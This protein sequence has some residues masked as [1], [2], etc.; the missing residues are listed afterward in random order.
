[1]T[2][3]I[4][5]ILS[6]SRRHRGVVLV[7]MLV[8]VAA[9]VVAMRGLRFDTNV[10]S[11]LP[12]TGTIVPAFSTFVE[13]FGSVDDLY[14]VLTAPQGHGIREYDD[15]VETWAAKLRATPG[16][17]RVDTGLADGSRDLTWFA[18][19]RL[20]LLSGDNLTKGLNRFNGA[21]LEEALRQ[22]RSLLTLPSA[23]VVQMVRYDPLGLFDLLRDELGALQAGVNL[24]AT[25]GGYISAD[26]QSRLLIAKPTRAPFD[27]EFSKQLLASLEALRR[28]RGRA[29]TS[30]RDPASADDERPPLSAEF[31]GGHRIAVETES[32]IRREAIMN[33]IGS[34]ALI[35]PLLYLVFRSPWLVV[36]GSI[37]S[38]V[39]LV[40]VLGVLGAVG[41]TLSAAATASS[42]MLFGLG[43]DGVVLL[44]VAYTHAIRA[45][46]DPN[47]AIDGL[48][49]PSASMLLGMCTTA[50]TF[51]GLLLVDF[52][53]LEQLGALI[54]HSMLVCGPL[55]LILV[56]ALL[57]RRR[58]SRPPRA[59]AMPR[60]A[61]WVDRHTRLILVSALALTI[62]MA[63]AATRLQINPTLDRLRA[64]TPGAIQLQQLGR[65]FGLP[66]E[67]YVVV[68]SGDDLDQL[69]AANERL[70]S[71]LS[72]ALPAVAVHAP[73]SLLPSPDVQQQRQSLIRQR[74]GT[75][76]SIATTLAKAETAEGFKADSF[77]PFLD[78]VP[79]LIDPSLRLTYEDYKAHGLDDLIGRFVSRH[80][81]HW[82]LA[83]YVFPQRPEDVAALERVVVTVDPS[84]ILTGLARVNRELADRFLPELLKGLSIGTIVVIV[85]VVIA[86]RDVRLSLL[87][88]VPTIIGLVWAAG[89]LAIAGAA[90]DLFALFAVVTFVGIGVDYGVHMVHRYQE[91][92][93]APQAVSELAPV[94]LTAALIT[95]LGYGTLVTSSYPPLRSIGLVSAVSVATLAL[96]SVFVLPAILS[97]LAATSDSDA[98]SSARPDAGSGPDDASA[99]APRKWTLHGLNNGVIFTLTYHG[100]RT[101][102]RSV[103]YALG[104]SLT[105]I[106]WRTL[107]RTREAIAHNLAPLF[108]TEDRATLERRALTTLRSYARDVVD[109]LRALD[110]DR[111]DPRRAFELIEESPDLVERLQARSHGAI[112]ITGHYGNWEAGSILIRHVL[113]WP[114]TIVAMAEADADVNRIRHIIRDKMGAETI[115]VQRSL[116]TAL[117]IRRHLAANRIV[118]MLVDRHYA[119]DR[120]AVTLFGRQAWFLRTPFVIAVATGAPLLPCAIERAGPGRFRAYIGEPIIVSRDLPRDEALAQAAQQVANALETRVRAHPEYWYHFYRY[121]DAQRDEYD[122][123]V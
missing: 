74:L 87:S 92:R 118:A 109:F 110:R 43:V 13:S 15:V 66:D 86:F 61:A 29:K 34:L 97:S 38:A 56:P 80:D 98:L 104:Y 33:T 20:L 77:A 1:V 44:Y 63:L 27:A 52:P 54:G 14:V 57:P 3:P 47:A 93:D 58:P 89:V 53:S 106:A 59:L 4:P 70:R 18:D 107:K 67:V 94:I 65:T 50:A 95:L 7:A 113:D 8:S 23:T 22:R 119:T 35:L 21:P 64:V 82:V 84:A 19:R 30:E 105:W 31:A 100:V 88:M 51:Y 5:A 117:Q 11:L 123:L 81:G 76:D 71:A 9:S 60:F 78:R 6:W 103:S 120:V 90:L 26:G 112:L 25:D 24:G 72:S 75:S 116:E 102:P 28:D 49:G 55:T 99:G 122:G 39:S 69:L 101:L 68:A 32:V 62:V 115:E 2:S 121:W 48:G 73:S 41:V 79:T 36:V 16:I 42:A 96:A 37:P 17:A 45:G 83:T 91:R 85:L 40:L 111:H 10:L 108:P 114:L 12:R 46:T